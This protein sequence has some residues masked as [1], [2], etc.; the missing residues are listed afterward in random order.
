MFTVSVDASQALKLTEKV[1]KQLPFTVRDALN[2]TAKDFQKAEQNLVLRE[3]DLKQ[4]DFILNSIKVGRDG[5]AR[6]NKLSVTIEINPDRN[7]L[8]KW[9]QGGYK[10]SIAGKSYVAVPSREIKLTKRGLVPRSLYP[11]TFGPFTDIHHGGLLALGQRDSFI[12]MSKT[13]LPILLQRTG[14]GKSGLRAIAIYKPEVNLG[15]A[16]LHFVRT[17]QATAESAWGP[18][19]AKAWTANI[20]TAR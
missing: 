19:F 11:S 9:E 2:A 7:Q 12:V 5:F 20:A 6:A 8:A 17:A 16:R 15:P 3:F 10:A 13:G 14:P 1:L 4:R 18:N